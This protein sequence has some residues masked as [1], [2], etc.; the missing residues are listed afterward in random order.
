MIKSSLQIIAIA[1][2][3][4]SLAIVVYGLMAISGIF[5]KPFGSDSRSN[6]L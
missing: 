2:V 6:P 4:I 5:L 3:G 1:T